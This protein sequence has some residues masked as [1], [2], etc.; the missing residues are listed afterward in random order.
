MNLIVKWGWTFVVG[1]IILVAG[2]SR[3]SPP[4]WIS[5]LV[6]LFWGGGLIALTTDFLLH[7]QIT[8]GGGKKVWSGF[9]VWDIHQKDIE[10][11]EQAREIAKALKEEGLKVIGSQYTEEGQKKFAVLVRR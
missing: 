10:T 8:F 1:L 6:I 3:D 9:K 5:Y 7:R 11:E 2:S 4:T